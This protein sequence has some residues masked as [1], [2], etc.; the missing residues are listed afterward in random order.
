MVLEDEVEIGAGCAI[1]RGTLGDTVI[2]KGT[3]LGD[4]NAIGHGTR[5]GPH[6]LIVAQVGVS[7]STTL[8]HHCV[9]G[10]QVGITGHISIGN[11]V[12][13]GAQAGVIN[14]VGDGKVIVGSPAIDASIAKR[15]YSMYKYL[16][17]MRK[18]IRKLEKEFEKIQKTPEPPE[19]NK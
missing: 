13:I 17:D 9:V 3:K 12:M 16:P 18:S 4:L 6:C 1:E 10:G 2:E 7:G 11:G 19:K 14:N 15:A 5:I 8:G